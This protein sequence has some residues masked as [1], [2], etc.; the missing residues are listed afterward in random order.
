MNRHERIEQALNSFKL[1]QER[2]IDM[3]CK[4]FGGAGAGE[5]DMIKDM[6]FKRSHTFENLKNE[7]S[8]ISGISKAHDDPAFL[9]C[10]LR[11]SE[12]LAKEKILTDL[13]KERKEKLAGEMETVRRGKKTLKGYRGGTNS[14]GRSME[15]TG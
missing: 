14:P 10:R 13:V 5:E 4:G 9:E 1:L 7:I 6:V 11:V 8:T 3:L 12:I 15:L 2:Q